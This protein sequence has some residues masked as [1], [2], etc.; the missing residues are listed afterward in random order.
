MELLLLAKVTKADLEAENA[1]LKDKLSVM[2]SSILSMQAENQK[3]KD[4]LREMIEDVYW[5][6]PLNE[7]NAGRKSKITPKLTERVH[8]LKYEQGKT[9]REISA[10]LKI[11]T[12]L[13]HKILN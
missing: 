13:V 12:G 1:I 10:Y 5:S 2:E 8:D 4:E 11:S 7:R 3:L 6:Q 9:I